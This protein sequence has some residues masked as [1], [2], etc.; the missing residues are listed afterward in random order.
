M[1]AFDYV[2]VDEAGR[3]VRGTLTT[4]V[5]GPCWRDAG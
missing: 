5:C 1:A 3:T 4:A 2:A